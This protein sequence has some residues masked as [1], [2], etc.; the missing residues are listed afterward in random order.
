MSEAKAPSS[1]RLIDRTEVEKLCSLGRNAIY[2]RINPK[3]PRFDP[4]FPKPIALGSKSVRWVFSEIQDYI[5]KK[6]E[7][8][9]SEKKAA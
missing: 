4:D 5:R 3:S 6:I 8:S 9:R 2:E 1:E 7:H